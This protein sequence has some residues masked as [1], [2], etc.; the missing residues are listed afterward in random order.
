MFFFFIWGIRTKPK[1]IGAYNSTCSNCKKKTLHGVIKVTKYFTFFFIPLIP[2]SKKVFI[3]C[4]ACG[5][6]AE[7]KGEMKEK[8]LEKL[9]AKKNEQ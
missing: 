7:V 5:M 9:E 2:L 6:K 8:L 4:E 1:V 3:A